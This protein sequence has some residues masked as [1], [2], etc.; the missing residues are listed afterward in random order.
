MSHLAPPATTPPIHLDLPL[1]TLH[2]NRRELFEPL[3]PSRF[4]RDFIAS[5]N[6]ADEILKLIWD[7]P[8]LNRHT[9]AYF[10]RFLQVIGCL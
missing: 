9:L 4:Y 2:C 3:V 7:L 10:V 6:K 5:Y 1:F 8:E